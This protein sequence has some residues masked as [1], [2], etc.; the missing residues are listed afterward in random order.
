MA[1]RSISR[2]LLTALAVSWAVPAA[3]QNLC[4]FTSLGTY[5][6]VASGQVTKPSNC[7]DDEFRCYPAEQTG[8][9]VTKNN[10]SCNPTAGSCQVKIH[11]TA[12]IPGLRDMILD[13]DLFTALTPLV[14][15]YPCLGAT[16][17]AKDMTCGVDG[18]GRITSTSWTTGWRGA[19][20]A[21][22]GT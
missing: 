13:M 6:W 17:C 19:C 5:E 22:A 16:G 10:P 11:A 3:A 8:W 14:E 1:L 12:T 4:G 15:W 9:S 18:A 20:M 21:T 7:N 2:G